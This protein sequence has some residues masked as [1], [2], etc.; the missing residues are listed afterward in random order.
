[1][2]INIQAVNFKAEASLSEYLHKKMSK[3]EIIYDKIT[4]A[5]VFFKLLNNNTKQNKSSEIILHI[6]GED[7]VV[8]KQGQSF[9]ECIDLSLDVIK[10]KLEKEKNK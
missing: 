1:M 5:S 6:P 10:T 9:E 8:K 3:I 4:S 2:T 7:I